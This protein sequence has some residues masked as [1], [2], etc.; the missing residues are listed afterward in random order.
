MDADYNQ[1]LENLKKRDEIDSTREVAPLRIAEDAHVVL[2]DGLSIEEVM[3]RVR[4][5]ANIE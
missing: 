1:I 3:Q 2:T 4:K 5:L